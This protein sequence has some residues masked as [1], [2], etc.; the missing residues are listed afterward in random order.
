MLK[1]ERI[2]EQFEKRLLDKKENLFYTCYRLA[3]QDMHFA[4]DIFQETLLKLWVY[5]SEGCRDW[6]G[7]DK[8][9]GR[10]A[11]RT[12]V[13]LL[14]KRRGKF[15]DENGRA[16]LRPLESR[17][18]SGDIADQ[19]NSSAAFSCSANSPPT[20]NNQKTK[21]VNYM[22]VEIIDDIKYTIEDMHYRVR[23]L[24]TEIREVVL[25]KSVGRTN[26]EIGRELGYS[27]MTASRKYREGLRRLRDS[28]EGAGI[29]G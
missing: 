22:P 3:N 18:K 6:N 21:L 5:Y 14:R 16:N 24:P 10:V 27:H 4:D 2:E 29:Y 28:L 19:L 23:Q 9:F 26:E 12:A 7:F 1:K 13:D 17:L 15:Y 20:R 25:R 8:I 11:S